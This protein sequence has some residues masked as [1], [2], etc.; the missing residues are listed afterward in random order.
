MAKVQTPLIS[1]SARGRIAGTV[2]YQRWKGRAYA[3]Q[4]VK[5]DDPKTAPQVLS[6][7]TFRVGDDIWV[8]APAL[9]KAPWDRYALGLGISGYNA[10]QGHY[11]RKN[12]GRPNLQATVF[13]PGARGG[14]P[15]T[16][17]SGVAGPG[18]ITVTFVNPAAPTGWVLESAI[19]AA[20]R[21]GDPAATTFI[22]PTVAEDAVTQTTVLLSGLTDGA[23]Y[24]FGGWLRW[25]KPDGSIAYG[26]SLGGTA[27]PVTPFAA[28]AV[29]FD[30]INDY[31]TRGAQLTGAA[32]SKS[33]ILSIWAKKAA[34][35]VPL[36]M[37]T[38]DSGGGGI[39]EKLTYNLAVNDRLN[40][41]CRNAAGAQILAVDNATDILVATG[42]AN[43]LSSWDLA[44]GTIQVY[45]NDAE[46]KGTE[47][48]NVDD[49]IDYTVPNAAVGARWTG[50]G[51]PGANK[52]DGCLA[53][54]YFQQGEFLDFSVEANRRKFISAA[55][56]P[57]DLGSDG[58]TPTGTVP[59]LFLSGFTVT[60]HTNDG[61]GGGLTETGALT[62][63][64]TS[65]SD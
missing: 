38:V 56:K 26:A 48:A 18:A 21:D 5:P 49:L 40:L 1:F 8:S 36:G 44:A 47:F 31:L 55:G 61:D 20:L 13:S 7:D 23:S 16:T 32:D 50:G 24:V 63:C 2:N 34:D 65:P 62:T 42:W 43:I 4:F 14:L 6:R 58:S 17:V 29:D 57:V 60:W 45:V 41:I 37:V 9:L 10:W 19:A 33:G 53:E 28:N 51:A 11:I 35:G 3:K 15:P 59:I 12:R 27:T 39:N 46:D 54:V 64:A 25:R 30:G 52:F 22:V